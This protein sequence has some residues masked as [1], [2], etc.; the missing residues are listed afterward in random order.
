MRWIE[1]FR[2]QVGPAELSVQ[3]SDDRDLSRSLGFRLPEDYLEWA[4]EYESLE[5]CGELI[6]W[7]WCSTRR[8]PITTEIASSMLAGIELGSDSPEGRRDVLDRQG[9]SIGPKPWIPA[10]P[11]PGGLFPW[12]TD[13]NG[14]L[15]LWDARETDPNN[16][17]V[18]TYNRIWREFNCG[19]VEFLVRLLRSE[20]RNSPMFVREWPWIPAIRELESDNEGVVEWHTPNR[21]R[22]YFEAFS[23][24][25][26]DMDFDWED[27]SWADRFRS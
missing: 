20:F 13:A 7:N 23:E 5:I 19:F 22:E 2:S 17:S 6:V 15:Y 9:T 4:S 27:F 18:L 11:G 21:W 12:G 16:W 14:T 8:V 25:E 26:E 10:I 24:I 1:E 3:R